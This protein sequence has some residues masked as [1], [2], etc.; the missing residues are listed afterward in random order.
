MKARRELY[1]V[2]KDEDGL[3]KV[4]FSKGRWSTKTKQEAL[5]I[6]KHAKKIDGE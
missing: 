1:E 5:H 6:A 3:W 4:Q 2:W